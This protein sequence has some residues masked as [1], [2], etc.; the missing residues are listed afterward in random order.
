MNLEIEITPGDIKRELQAATDE[1]A[2]R[3]FRELKR[4]LAPAAREVIDSSTP[5]GNLYARKSGEG[6]KRFH[7]ASAKG[8]VPA[9]DSFALYN[10]FRAQITGEREITFSMAEHARWLDSLF[11]GYLNRP[12][13]EEAIDLGVTRALPRSI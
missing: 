13:L 7:R 3:F 4:E 10:S 2:D 1:A 9:K 11:G 12:F 5:S 6:F 8:E